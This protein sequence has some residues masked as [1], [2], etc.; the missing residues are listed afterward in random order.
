MKFRVAREVLAEA[1]A[2]TARTWQQLRRRFRSLPNHPPQTD[3]ADYHP[4][5]NAILT[6]VFTAETPLVTSVGMPIGL[7]LVC[8]ARKK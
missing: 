4:V 5:V 3:F 1:V 8:F 6:A 2:W 7:S